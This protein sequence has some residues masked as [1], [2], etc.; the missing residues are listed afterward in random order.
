MMDIDI[1]EQLRDSQPKGTKDGLLLNDA[2]DE[3]VR[4]RAVLAEQSDQYGNTEADPFH[5]CTFP[6]CGCD[7]ARLCQARSGANDDAARCNV[8]GMYQSKGKTAVRAK[9]ELLRLCR[10]NSALGVKK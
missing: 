6:D 7:G 3:I 10:P 1:V 2:A 9:M 4:L 8:E 5:F